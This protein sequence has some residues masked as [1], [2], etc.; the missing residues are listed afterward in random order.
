MGKIES[1]IS[2]C[3]KTMAFSFYALIYF[4]PIS[5]ALTEIF[6]TLPL[7]CWFLK[8]GVC[9]YQSLKKNSVS[10][11]PFF[12][13]FSFF[14]KSFKP[15]NNYLTIPITF[16]L[17]F[18]FVSMLLSHHRTV[19]LEGFLGKTLQNA[20][21]YF[22][23]IEC[24]NS[25]KRLRLF[26]KV[27]F[28]SATLICI[29]G[30]YQ[31][32]LGREFVHGN[33]FNGRISSSLRHPNDFGAY[34]VVI[35][36]ILLSAALFLVRRKEKAISGRK[37]FISRLDALFSL[38]L[39]LTASVCLGLTYSRGAW[40][41]FLFA[42][43][44]F[45]LRRG[46]L[47]LTNL[48]IVLLFFGIFYPQLREYRHINLMTDML[49]EE[50]QSSESPPV[51]QTDIDAVQGAQGQRGAPGSIS[52]QERIKVF[53]NKIWQKVASFAS[54]VNGSG[55]RGYWQEAIDI[56]KDYPVFGVGINAYSLVAPQYKIVWG[57]YPH[58]CYLQMLVEI[59]VV[60][61]LSFLWIL[62]R[63]FKNGAF[64]DAYIP[65]PFL[66]MLLLGVMSGLTGF[67][68]HSI[69]DTNFYSVQLGSFMWIILGL[70]VV[71][72][73]IGN[74]RE[75]DQI[76][77]EGDNKMSIFK[78]SRSTTRVCLFLLISFIVFFCY[79]QRITL[80]PRYGAIFYKVGKDCFYCSFE[81]KV[82]YFQRAIYF[83]PNLSKAYY[84]L[85]ELYEAHENKERALEYYLKAAALDHA[86]EEAYFKVGFLY[87]QD[88]KPSYALRYLKQ[89]YQSTPR[90]AKVNYYLALVYES[91]KRYA[92]ALEYYQRI[93]CGQFEKCAQASAR[94]G[95]LY[96]L[97]K[98]EAAVLNKIGDLRNLQRDDLAD[99]LQQFTETN[100]YPE[101]MKEKD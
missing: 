74:Q 23:F 85:G 14:F 29:N 39:F 83:D 24:I 41:G 49:T 51:I 10:V 9:F 87:F 75:S 15:V 31:Y 12:Y 4:L 26:L 64:K 71:I 3:D 97:L 82:N 101:F 6:S 54:T 96:H 73:K 11:R 2:W 55:R 22:N 57:G 21:I 52:G 94:V 28:I 70:I 33:V 61:F 37:L 34:L 25:R 92:D 72:P 76:E 81:K 95:V 77:K 90:D 19:S 16:F 47:V 65:D 13:K 36:P 78:I 79:L 59:G 86:F 46:Q 38:I 20:F 8:R 88:G 27:F 7:I 68:I 62:L 1:F 67:L 30:I 56:I 80:N 66:R 50:K 63:V 89:A 100:Q 5:I 45:C 40:L 35:I 42:I 60:G 48:V 53:L 93:N 99:Q 32:Y 18:N 58:N 44:Y 91:E 43:I 17:F 69:F 98:N 84:G